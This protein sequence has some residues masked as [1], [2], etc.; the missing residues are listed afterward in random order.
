M[1][2]AQVVPQKQIAGHR[3]NMEAA[4]FVRE[5]ATLIPDAIKRTATLLFTDR[6]V[7]R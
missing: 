3:M 2:S 1:T 5:W 7:H 4:R 6:N